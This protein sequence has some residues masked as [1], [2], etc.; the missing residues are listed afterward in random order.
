MPG[1][2]AG[3][4][5]LSGREEVIEFIEIKIPTSPRIKSGDLSEVLCTTFAHECTPF[6]QGVKR[7]RWKDH[8]NMSMRDEDLLGFNP[9][10]AT[11]QLTVLTAELKSGTNMRSTTVDETWKALPSFDKVPSP[12]AV[13]FVAD[14]LTEPNEITLRMRLTISNSGIR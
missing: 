13:S 5:F 9:N 12:H 8:R 11:G 4:F 14:R 7:L 10:Q 1:R 3:L 2:L 6:K